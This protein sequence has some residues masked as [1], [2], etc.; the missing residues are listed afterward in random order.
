MKLFGITEEGFSKIHMGGAQPEIWAYGLRNPYAFPFDKKTAT[1]SSP[2]SA[3]TTRGD[4]LAAGRQQGRRELRLE[5]NMGTKCHPMT[6]PD[7]KCPIVGVLPVAEYPHQEPYP[8]RR[9]AEGRLGLLG[10]GPRRR[11]LRRH[12]RRVSSPA[13]GARAACSAPAGTARS[14]SCRSWLQTSLQFTSGNTTRT[15]P[16]SPST[17]TASIPTIAGRPAIL[18]G[19]SGKWCRRPK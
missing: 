2:T 18:P 14:G 1:C 12:G 5:V 16:C 7:D 19:R 6:G 3:R 17:A 4:R 10:H 13:T 15:A 8:G 11:Q 9:E